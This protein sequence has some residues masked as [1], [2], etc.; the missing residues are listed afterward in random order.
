MNKHQ[1]I[2]FGVAGL[3]AFAYLVAWTTQLSGLGFVLVLAFVV[4]LLTLPFT[5]KLI[6][7]SIKIV[8]G[9]GLSLIGHG[10]GFI[11][12]WVIGRTNAGLTALSSPKARFAQQAPAWSELQPQPSKPGFLDEVLT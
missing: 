6:I 11:G 12:D 3:L 1:N 8:L 10:I 7:G 2:A 9:H 4:A 5:W